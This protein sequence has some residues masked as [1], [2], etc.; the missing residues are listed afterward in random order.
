MSDL[1]II[2]RKV[3]ATEYVEY[4]RETIVAMLVATGDAFGSVSTTQ[5]TTAE[6]ATTLVARL[7]DYGPNRTMPVAIVA[8]RFGGDASTDYDGGEFHDWEIAR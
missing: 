1:V 4:D 6:L 3:V 2:R 8:D 7:N 5:A